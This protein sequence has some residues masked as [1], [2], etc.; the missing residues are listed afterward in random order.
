MCVLYN[1]LTSNRIEY[2]RGKVPFL[3]SNSESCGHITVVRISFHLC[4]NIRLITHMIY[5]L[6]YSALQITPSK[7]P[8]CAHNSSYAPPEFPELPEVFGPAG[9]GDDLGVCP[10]DGVG[11]GAGRIDATAAMEKAG[12]GIL[13]GAFASVVLCECEIDYW[14]G[15]PDGVK[16]REIE[17]REEKKSVEY[18]PMLWS[19]PSTSSPSKSYILLP[20]LLRASLLLSPSNSRFAPLH[21]HYVIPRHS[22]KRI[23]RQ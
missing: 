14:S 13:R 4:Q 5:L 23:Q 21:S 18:R 6:R 1:A 11:V 10:A 19:I 8:K 20:L 2:L 15:R 7:N 17:K 16:R 9:A 22:V 12:E 3:I